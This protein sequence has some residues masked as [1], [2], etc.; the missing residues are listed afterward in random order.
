ML[1]E[2]TANARVA[3]TEFASNAGIQVGAI[4]SARQGGFTV[5]DANEERS[6]SRKIE[7]DIRVVTTIE[8]YLT[9]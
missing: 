1:R 3:A 2:A 7:K 4:R 6:E 8:F 5:R 9:E